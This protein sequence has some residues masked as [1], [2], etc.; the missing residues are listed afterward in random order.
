MGVRP[1]RIA[2]QILSAVSVPVLF[3]V[4]R[5]GVRYVVLV[6]T[7]LQR[8]IRL[9]GHRRTQQKDQGGRTGVGSQLARQK[10][11]GTHGYGKHKQ[12]TT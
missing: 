7:R 5:R 9:D 3:G 11:R 12:I 10:H 1:C 2:L 4:L 6:R 8:R